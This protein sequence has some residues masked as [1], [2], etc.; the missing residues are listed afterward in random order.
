MTDDMRC[1]RRG[2][3]LVLVVAICSAGA[4]LAAQSETAAERPIQLNRKA[5][6]KLLMTQVTPEYPSI[7]RVNYIRGQ[8]RML[9][10]VGRTGKVSLAHVLQGHPFLAASA[11][12]AI[13][14]WVYRPFVTA[15][16]PAEFLTVVDVNFTLRTTKA[17]RLPPDPDY[18]LTRQVHPPEALETPPNATD[19]VRMRVLVNDGGHAIDATPLAGPPSLFQAARKRIEGWKFRPARWGNF[20][21]PWYVD[22]SVPMEDVEPGR[23]N[24]ESLGTSP[25]G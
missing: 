19:Y 3:L 25:T 14:R 15:S 21:V 6:S 8:V 16:G 9:V 20:R 11:L 24:S 13:H 18:D 2:L 12:E 23:E 5:A 7:A 17:D 22:V 1:N 4:P 10:M